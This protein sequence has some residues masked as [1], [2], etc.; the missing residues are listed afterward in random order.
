M[1]TASDL[2][3]LHP[4][5]L[6]VEQRETAKHLGYFFIVALTKTIEMS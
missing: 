3:Q 4:P 6:T 2:A 5:L 1:M